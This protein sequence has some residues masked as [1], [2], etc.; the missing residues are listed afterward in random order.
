MAHR[1]KNKDKRRGEFVEVQ[2]RMTEQTV[3]SKK[4]YNRKKEKKD[5]GEIN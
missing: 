1:I 4:K 2:K 3:V 5:Y